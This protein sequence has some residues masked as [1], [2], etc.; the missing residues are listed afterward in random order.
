[1]VRCHFPPLSSST[2]PSHSPPSHSPFHSPLPLSP[3]TLPSQLVLRD[4]QIKEVP[5]EIAYCSNLQQ[6]H[7]QVNQ[8]NVLPVELGEKTRGEGG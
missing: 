2:L 4:N 7:L 6:F 8:I 5:P 1:M 3:P